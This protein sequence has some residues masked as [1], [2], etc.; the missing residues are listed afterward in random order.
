MNNMKCMTNPETSPVGMA[1]LG[2]R[3]RLIHLALPD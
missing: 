3:S 2:K 1:T